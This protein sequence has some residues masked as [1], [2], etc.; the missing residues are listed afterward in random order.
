MYKP[1]SG[2]MGGIAELYVYFLKK[3]P[4]QFSKVVLLFYTSAS[5]EFISTIKR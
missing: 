3:L 5:K 4:K 2:H 1:L